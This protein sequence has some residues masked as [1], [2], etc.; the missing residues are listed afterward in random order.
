MPLAD[1]GSSATVRAAPARSSSATIW[2]S[3]SGRP[4]LTNAFCI[5]AAARGAAGTS[6]AALPAS[7]AAATS[8]NGP[9]QGEPSRTWIPT[10]PSGACTSVERRPARRAGTGPSRWSASAAGPSA[11]SPCNPPTDGSS[12]ASIASLRGWPASAAS[13]SASASASSST[14]IAAR[15]R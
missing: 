15:R 11:A 10:T 4:A 5:R 7:S 3:S 13:R 2:N 12:S 6:N 14:A 1:G 8:S 9:A